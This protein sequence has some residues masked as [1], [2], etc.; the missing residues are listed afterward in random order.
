MT[1][2]ASDS[3]NE[4]AAVSII[5]AIQRGKAAAAVSPWP[6]RTGHPYRPSSGTEGMEFDARWCNHCTR[7]AEYRNDPDNVDP[8]RGCQ[9]IADTFA[10]EITDPKYPKEW[11]YGKD[12]TPCCTAFTTD[13]TCPVRCD[14]TIDMFATHQQ[15]PERE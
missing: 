6:E 4:Q 8:S 14:K 5:A 10:F 3:A 7:D 2:T 9:I 15:Q 12:G 11:I 1:M 13:P